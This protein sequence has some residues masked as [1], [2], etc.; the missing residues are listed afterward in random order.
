MKLH[1]F[2][3]AAWMLIGVV[4]ASPGCG[5][6]DESQNASAEELA[7]VARQLEEA[8]RKMEEVTRQLNEAKLKEGKDGVSTPGSKGEPAGFTPPPDHLEPFDQSFGFGDA[9]RVDHFWR[10]NHQWSFTSERARNAKWQNYTFLACRYKL[11][12]DFEIKIQGSMS[13]SY[14]NSKR[15]HLYVAGQ[16]IKLISKTGKANLDVNIERVGNSLY[17]TVVPNPTRLILL[18]EEQAGPTEVL[19]RFHNRHAT[20]QKFDLKATSADRI[21]E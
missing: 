8:T 10:W 7:K 21:V 2:S 12:G 14:T 3:L 1:Y 19:L 18:T 9:I 16:E 11:V 17:C 13:R 15:P 6:G 4:I 5:G 20:I